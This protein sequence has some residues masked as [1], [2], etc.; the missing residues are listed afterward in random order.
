MTKLQYTKCKGEPE[1]N[2]NST[3]LGGASL[4]GVPAATCALSN[5]IQS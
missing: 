1:S 4:A 5:S 3:V 2:L